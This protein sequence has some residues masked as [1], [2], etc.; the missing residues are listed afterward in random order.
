MRDPDPMAVR[1]PVIGPPK[2]CAPVADA[3]PAPDQWTRPPLA[4]LLLTSHPLVVSGAPA[5]PAL[6][7][8]AASRRE[9]VFFLSRS[10]ILSNSLTTV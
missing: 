10:E 7:Q 2:H 8:V 5:G 4:C 6:R 3:A 1:L 9:I